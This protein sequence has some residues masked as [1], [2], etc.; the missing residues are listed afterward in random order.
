MSDLGTFLGCLWTAY[1]DK[2]LHI[3][4]GVVIGF[5]VGLVHPAAGIG[6]AIAAGLGKELYDMRDGGTGFDSADLICTGIG[7]IIGAL[8]AWA[9]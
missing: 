4:A 9:I 7:G 5:V 1:G 6:A 3:V 2:V 8:T